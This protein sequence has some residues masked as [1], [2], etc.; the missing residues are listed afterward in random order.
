[1]N[2]FRGRSSRPE[3]QAVAVAAAGLVLIAC[4][5][6]VRHW[7]YAHDLI[8]DTGIYR[9]DAS[10]VRHGEVPYRD[11]PFEYPPGALPVL[12][13][14]IY[15][16]DYQSAFGWLMAGLAVCMLPVVASVRHAAAAFVAVS[17]LLVGALVLNRFDLWPALLAAAAVAALVRDR[18]RL[19]WAAL[20]AALAAK[21]WAVS[22]VPLAVVWTLR[23]RGREE[24]VRAIATGTAVVAVAFVPFAVVAPHGLWQ[25]MWG[26]VTRP[27]QIESLGAAVLMVTHHAGVALSHG[28]HDPAG[29][30]VG[31]TQALLEALEAAVLVSLWV[32]FARGPVD[33]ERFVRY[34]AACVAAF[35]A[36][37]KVL[38]PQ[39]LIWLVPLVPLV[40]GRRG[41][42]ATALLAFA[43]VLTQVWYPTRYY[44]YVYHYH[45]AWV[46]LLRDLVLVALLVPLAAPRRA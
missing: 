27:M 38:S 23:R 46:V 12:V 20:G 9:Q 15:L 10:L 19:G 6:V 17:P 5:V 42:W 31:P 43:L 37:G 7:F 26:Q 33:R 44:A 16:G 2:P 25:S 45:L 40:R 30:A 41:L 4:W 35:V 22:L 18:H 28:S 8:G 39:Y 13:A 11:F 29:V 14:P 36:F 3:L 21:L 1:M 34:T 32:A 24:L